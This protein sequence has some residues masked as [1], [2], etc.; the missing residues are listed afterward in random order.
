[1]SD[2]YVFAP[3]AFIRSALCPLNFKATKCADIPELAKLV[4]D[5]P[6]VGDL[7]VG[8]CLRHESAFPY[9]DAHKHRKLGCQLVTASFGLAPEDIELLFGLCTYIH[10]LDQSEGLSDHLKITLNVNQLA[11]HAGF[12]INGGKDTRRLQ[13]RILRLSYLKLTNT[14]VWNSGRKSYESLDNMSLFDIDDMSLL[15]EP[16]QPVTLQLSHKFVELLRTT[17][18]VAFDRSQW[19]SHKSPAKRRLFVIVHR[20][21]WNQRDSQLYDADEFAIHQL[22]YARHDNQRQNANRRRRRLHDLRALLDQFQKQELICPYAPWGSYFA[23]PNRGPLA[24][25]LCVRWSRGPAVRAK[26]APSSLTLTAEED[27]LYDQLKT[28]T[29]QQGRPLSIPA[30]RRLLSEHGRESLQRHAHI[31]LAQKQCQ[32]GSFRKSEVAAF[33]NRVKHN[34]PA[35]D[36]YAAKL[37]KP[38][39][40]AKGIQPSA[41]IRKLYDSMTINV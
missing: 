27:A 4:E 29:D 1:M 15:V 33:V 37:R 2:Q 14:A 24:G 23:T 18:R 40:D 21:G 38:R 31:V 30:Y 11:R 39:L 22:G 35:P 17:P 16:W 41:K 36:W 12:E 10:R 6:A 5:L 8:D 26:K 25:R 28:L 13:S 19:R 34:H 32:P 3:L 9:W 7:E 20:E